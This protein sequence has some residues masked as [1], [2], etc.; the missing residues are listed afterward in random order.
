MVAMQ[1]TDENEIEIG[2]VD[3]VLRLSAGSSVG[4][5]SIRIREPP[6]SIT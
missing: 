6:D 4:P 2:G 3:L 1:M 5:A